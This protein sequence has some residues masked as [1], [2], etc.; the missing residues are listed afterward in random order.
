[1]VRPIEARKEG[2]LAGVHRI[3]VDEVKKRMDEGELI[4]LID[5][6]NSHDWNE[7]GVKAWVAAG[8][9]VTTD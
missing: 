8:F 6:R 9:P 5:T 2:N 4:L 7:S 1:L 3:T